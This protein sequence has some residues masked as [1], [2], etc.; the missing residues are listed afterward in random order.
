MYVAMHTY[1]YIILV[2]EPKEA[3]TPSPNVNEALCVSPRFTACSL[4]SGYSY[5]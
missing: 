3:N 1:V 2:L 5:F 4:S